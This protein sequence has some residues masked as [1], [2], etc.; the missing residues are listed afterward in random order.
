M[1]TVNKRAPIAS[2]TTL[3]VMV[4]LVFFCHPMPAASW[5]NGDRE[6]LQYGIDFWQEAQGFPSTRIRDIVQARD[7]YLW[8]ATYSGLVRFDG[9]S[10]ALFNLKTGSLK[11]DEVWAL[12]ED[13]EGGLWIGTYGGG[14]TRLKD[15]RFTTFTTADGLPDDA[16]RSIDVDPDGNVWVGT[17]RGACRYS[18][19]S[20]TSFTTKDGL[21]NDFVTAICA[22]SRQGIFAAAGSKLHHLVGGRFV[23]ESGII[24]EK[25]GRISSLSGGSDGSIWIASEGGTVKR[26]K[27]GVVTDCAVE[28][29]FSAGD[30]KVYV[31]RQGTVWMGSGDGLR[32]L[33]NGKFEDFFR[34]R[35]KTGLG[36]VQSLCLDREGSLWIGLETNG[37]ARLR[38]AQFATLT[39]EDGLPHNS[40][41]S[42]FQDSRGD[43]WI[44]T[45]NGFSKLSGGKISSRTDL[46]GSPI[47]HVSSIAE[48][49]EGNLWLGA[50]GQLFKVLKDGR[51]VKDPGWKKVFE[52]KTIYRDPLNRMWVGTDGDGLFGFENGRVTVYRV[53]DGLPSNQV[54]G[55]LNDRQG[56]LW[57]TTFGG[58]VSRFADGKFTNYTTKDGL[59]SDR[60]VAVHEADDGSLWF[61]TRAG[62]SRYQDGRFFTYT[63]QEGL[64]VNQISGILEDEKGSFW[65]SCSQ[66]IFRVRKSDFS[67][68]AEGKIARLNCISYGVGDGLRSSAFAAGFQPN[69]CKTKDGQLLFSSLK[70]LAVFNPGLLLSNA[71]VPPVHIE[72]VLINKKAVDAGN[73]AE[74][75][76]G[77]GEVEI[78]YSALNYLAPEKMQFKYRLEG[79]DKA[80]VDAGTRR[81]AHYAGLSPG[82]YQFRVIA[83]NND[84]V[85]NES[86][87][88]FAFYLKPHYYQTYWFYALCGA[89]A[90]GAAYRFYLTRINR[91]KAEF[92]AVTAERNRIA[93]EIHDTLAQGF[94]GISVQLE[95]GKQTL[96]DSPQLAE[97]H[98]DQ[99]NNLARGCLEEVRR[100]VWNLRH[101]D[102]GKGDLAVRLSELAKAIAVGVPFQVKIFG[103]P[104]QLSEPTESILLRIGQEAIVNAVKHAHAGRIE[105]EILF[106]SRHVRLRVQDDGCGIDPEEEKAEDNGRFGM[107]GMRERANQLGGSLSVK[108]R[109]GH[110]TEIEAKVPLRA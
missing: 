100:Y 3:A 14:L 34:G 86:G 102:Q 88:A 104:R 32:I 6:L 75:P 52:I 81:F 9:V 48:D 20:F 73:H 11:Y 93:R 53:Q 66:G 41:L 77:E 82:Q 97:E 23:V 10:F 83:C 64:P 56:T 50:G 28:K 55:I 21:S 51:L 46:N 15:G 90:L 80:W 37:L 45:A 96:F 60:V 108:S 106:D 1:C 79:S 87:D 103:T 40:V 78:H 47:R 105:A 49:M 63:I 91:M 65:F 2:I 99:A 62:L 107:L 19:G 17:L 72:K 26:L 25:D 33:R 110:G 43:I 35:S 13:K 12:K 94:A 84:G 95:A 16:I 18:Q 57:V 58:G 36:V 61:A 101:R 89:L 59:G 30:S 71:L 22:A 74:I 98:L 92:A 39:D 38:K 70:G 68:L 109:P 7:G 8:M 5:N 67:G 4:H 54:R 24:E 85:W 27:D 29:A 44:G 31:D 42:V 69:A 76:P